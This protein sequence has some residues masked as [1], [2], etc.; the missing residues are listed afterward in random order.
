MKHNSE[1]QELDQLVLSISNDD[2]QV[3]DKELLK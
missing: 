2:I 1:Y 3:L